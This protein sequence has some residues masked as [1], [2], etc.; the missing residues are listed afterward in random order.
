[1]FVAADDYELFREH[2]QRACARCGCAVHAYVL[3]TNHVH[4]LVTPA[5]EGAFAR[6]MQSVGRRYV[7]YFN[8]TYHRS[9]TLWEGRYRST[10]IDSEQYFFA[11]HRYIETNP[12]R[13]GM[14]ASPE[15]YRWSSYRA[16]ALGSSDPLITAHQLYGALGVDEASRLAAYRALFRL[17]LTEAAMRQIR[18]ASTS[19]LPLRTASAVEQAR[20][21]RLLSVD[22]GPGV[23]D[24][25]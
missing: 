14:V 9:G 5:T 16:N 20:W 15:E 1:M 23:G 17:E 18:R 22:A 6:V 12:V 3:M 21:T 13:A 10:A 8:L 2:L 4:L 25:G 7:R 11:C 19:G 24:G